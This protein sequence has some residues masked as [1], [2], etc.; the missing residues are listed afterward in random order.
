MPTCLHASIIR[1]ITSHSQSSPP[2]TQS[3]ACVSS[4]HV[5]VSSAYEV[6][7]F[8]T[9]L[10]YTFNWYAVSLTLLPEL[11]IDVMPLLFSSLSETNTQLR[12]SFVSLSDCLIANILMAPSESAVSTRVWPPA[13]ARPGGPASTLRADTAEL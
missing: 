10:Q 6:S 2:K 4:F 1:I 5:Y 11:Y 12:S 13:P 7:A 8:Q 9:R 3:A